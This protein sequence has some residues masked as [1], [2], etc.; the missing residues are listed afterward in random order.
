MARSTRRTTP[1]APSRA[2]RS[3][4]LGSST[5]TDNGP[6]SRESDRAN[7]GA[8]KEDAAAGNVANQNPDNGREAEG[9]INTYIQQMRDEQAQI[10]LEGKFSGYKA[11]ELLTPLEKKFHDL[12]TKELKLS[13]DTADEIFR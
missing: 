11:G 13:D 12:L 6:G 10:C 7:A 5:R 8:A 4:S 2:L 9:N 1:R 3:R